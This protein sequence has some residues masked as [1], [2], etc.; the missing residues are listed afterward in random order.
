ATGTRPRPTT[1]DA[2]NTAVEMAAL[3]EPKVDYR[4][5]RSWA[6]RARRA[7]TA[8]HATQFWQ[9]RTNVWRK[10]TNPA[11]GAKR[12][13]SSPGSGPTRRRFNHCASRAALQM[14]QPH[15]RP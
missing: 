1:T 2:V 14:E 5:G 15:D 3:Q 7:M 6:G 4:T 11:R 8:A 12:P 13:R 9:R 10:A